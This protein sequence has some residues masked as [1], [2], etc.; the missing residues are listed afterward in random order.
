MLTFSLGAVPKL[1]LVLL[2]VLAS[3][4]ATALS[5]FQ[6]AHVPEQG[7]VQA[8]AGIDVSVPTGTII[9]TIDA[10][11]TL[12]SVA[13]TRDLTEAEK[14]AIIE[15]GANLALNPPAALAHAGLAVA[16]FERWEVGVRYAAGAWRL[17]VR[18]QLLKQ[19]DDGI[20]LSVGLGG[21]R[22]TQSY[23]IEDVLDTLEV[24]EFTRWNVDVPVTLGK[25][26]DFYRWWTGPRLL[27]TTMSSSIILKLPPDEVEVASVEGDGLYVG[28]MLGGAIGYKVIFLAAELTVAQLFSGADLTL[29]GDT[30]RV[31]L[32]SLVIYPAVGL[33]G[34]F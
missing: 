8:E 1:A 19:D 31:D 16:P 25:H 6:P 26:G 18:H 34:E 17:G 22:G 28:G 13:E 27:Y 24:E 23:P 21:S 14:V 12:E 5:S 15:A 3:G 32:D 4:C 11:E 20:D 2:A 30:R 7:H 33:M 10:A 9:K 29:L